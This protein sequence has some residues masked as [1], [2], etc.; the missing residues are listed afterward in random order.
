MIKETKND[1]VIQLKGNQKT[2]LNLAKIISENNNPLSTF[3]QK[4]NKDHGRIDSRK[5]EVFEIPEVSKTLDKDWINISCIVKTCR[6]R[7]EFDANEK[8]YKNPKIN[9]AYHIS[10][11]IYDAKTLSNIIQGHWGIEN[12]VNYVKD[13]QF[14]EDLSRIRVKAGIFARLRSLAL[15]IMRINNVKNISQTRFANC[16]NINYALTCKGIT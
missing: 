14:K 1:A 8:N 7:N 10:T 16:C 12:K 3:I 4:D 11:K 6:K 15:N 9:T 5:T 13:V 2:L